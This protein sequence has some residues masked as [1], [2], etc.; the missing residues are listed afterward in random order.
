MADSSPQPPKT[1]ADLGEEQIIR[2]FAD[3]VLPE[4]TLGIGD[5]CAVVPGVQGQKQLISTD[6]LIEGVH[7]K[8]KTID[9]E[10][11][12]HKA[13]SVNL[14]DIAAMGG[15]PDHFFLS[16]A[17]PGKLRVDWLDS[18]RDGLL[19]RAGEYDIPLLGGD[20]TRSE[21]DVVVSVMIIGHVKSEH[22][23]LRS[24][25]Q[26]GDRLC[27]TGPLGDSAAGLS[28]LAHSR[29]FQSL[30]QAHRRYLAGRHCR[31][32]PE[33]HAGRWLGQ[34]SSVHAMID[35]SD[36]LLSDARHLSRQSQCGINI[37]LDKLPLSPAF[38]AFGRIY[39]S[40]EE[41]REL[42]AAGGEDYCLLLT[43]AGRH[44]DRLARRFEE[45]FGRPLHVIG[46]VA[47]GPPGLYTF[48]NGERVQIRRQEFKH[49]NQ[50]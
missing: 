16:L 5:D 18:F 48:H 25:A 6:L 40:P 49:F 38:E 43:V 30:S 14:P 13:L 20:T 3:A 44:Y 28:L 17:L 37:A 31:P 11:L 21:H 2:R 4:D 34:Q 8:R 7:F 33:M 12:G 45:R 35:L 10:D 27:V 41:V 42:A 26:P 1:I 29:K 19:E 39:G 9:P 47:S 50:P 24:Q 36:G 22:L 15:W 46:S 23:K 32:R